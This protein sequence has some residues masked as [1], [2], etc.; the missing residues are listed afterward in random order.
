VATAPVTKCTEVVGDP[1][2]FVTVLHSAFEMAL[3][4]PTP[5]NAIAATAVTTARPRVLANLI[6]SPLR[7][8][9]RSGNLS[10]LFAIQYDP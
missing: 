7:K 10:G 8:T 2:G 9:A 4:E 1:H 5:R 6:L 3:A